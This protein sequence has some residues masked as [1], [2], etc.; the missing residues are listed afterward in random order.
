MIP[1]APPLLL[2]QDDEVLYEEVV[3]NIDTVLQEERGLTPQ[4][5]QP[6]T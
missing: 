5:E 2:L 3:G 4:E 1:E 6:S